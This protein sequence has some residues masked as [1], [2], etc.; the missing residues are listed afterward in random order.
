MRFICRSTF[1]S[2][3]ILVIVFS[4]I[5]C[6]GDENNTTVGSTK[7][8]YIINGNAQTLSMFD[9]EKSEMKNDVFNIGKW[10]ADIKIAGDKAYVVNTGDNNVQIVD[11]TTLTQAGIINTG[12][13]TSPERIAFVD[14]NKAYVTC[15]YTNSVKAVD[16]TSQKV[17]KD[18]PVGAGPMGMTI[19]NKKA[20]VCNPAYDFA[21]NSYG[22]GTISVID[23]A[24][25]SVIKTIH[26]AVKSLLCVLATIR[27]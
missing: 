25:D 20:Y 5:G 19:A 16:L 12:D 22:K 13:N 4:L 14:S 8:V 10:S 27:M 9:I 7:A 11:L 18:V 3:L 1:A 24:T 15:L 6:G 17:T 23:S 2:L 21:S 26:L